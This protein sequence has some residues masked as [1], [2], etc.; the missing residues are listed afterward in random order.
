MK[1]FGRYALVIIGSLLTG[2]ALFIGSFVA[3]DFVW[4]HIV[5]PNP[6]EHRSRRRSHG[7]WRGIHNGLHPR[8]CRA[9]N[10]PLQILATANTALGR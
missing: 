5:V 7:R 9:G 3:L 8:S 10:C 2:A 4:T 1:A 6:K